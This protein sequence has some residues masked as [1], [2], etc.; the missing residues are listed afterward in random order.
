[1][2]VYDER[3]ALWKHVVHLDTNYLKKRIFLL[4]WTIKRFGKLF[5]GLTHGVFFS[6]F[7]YIN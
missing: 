7:F 3:T 5:N 2:I 1:V 6:D 4:H